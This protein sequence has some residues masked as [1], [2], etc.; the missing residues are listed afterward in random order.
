MKNQ[1]LHLAKNFIASTHRNLFLTGKAGT[2]K[3]T[4]LKDLKTQTYKRMVVVAPTGVA[5][6]NAGGVTI[7]S[8]FQMPFGPLV[9]GSQETAHHVK[10]FSRQKIDIIRT[11]DLLVID[12]ISMVR[13]DL[14]DGIDQTLRRFKERNR[15]FGGVQVL[16]IGDIQQLAP[17]VKQE[18]WGLLSSHY[19]TPFFFSSK[20]FRE[21]D[22]I[23]VEL[24]KIYRQENEDFIHIL[25]EIRN[26]KVSQN[27]LSKLNKRYNPNF[28]PNEEENYITLTTHNRVANKINEKKINAIDEKSFFFEAMI[29]GNF[30]EY[31]YPTH[32][33]LE[34]KKG[35]QVMFVKNDSSPEKRY[36]NGKIGTVIYVD[37][38]TVEVLCTG[39]RESI[40]VTPEIWENVNY[41]IDKETKEIKEEHIGSFSQIPL[42]WAWAIT[43]HKSQGLT[44]DKAIIDAS[45]SFAHGQTYV[46]LSRCRSLEGVVLKSKISQD[47]IINDY[48]VQSF[49]ESTRENLP[50]EQTLVTAQVS[51]QLQLMA[52][53][54]DFYP[55]VY[56]VQAALQV[57]HKNKNTLKGVLEEPLELLKNNLLPNLLK[58]STQFKK[59]LEQI[60]QAEVLPEKDSVIQER[61][62]KALEYYHNFLKERLI[63]TFGQIKF[64]T[65]NKEIRKELEK[66][67]ES[68]DDFLTQKLHVYQHLGSEFDTQKYLKIRAQAV[69]QKQTKPKRKRTLETSTEHPEL[70]TELRAYRMEMA[71]MEMIPVYQVFTQE[72]LYEIL[73]K[74][75]DFIKPTQENKRYG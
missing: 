57:Y 68:I 37:K 45:G 6:I 73:R 17:V 9:P 42:K 49:A 48:R 52:Q 43:I 58:I 21:A 2:G 4:F 20:A 70:F 66:H 33:K 13:A 46:A 14:L 34:L 15:P 38:E 30:P 44:F 16:M 32:E 55:L 19:E 39:E 67:L 75:T 5:A 11:L 50:D 71:E 22:V 61:F 40:T 56:A 10:K 63:E 36:Y 53:V 41:S 59:Q 27:T 8:F 65:D 29:R 64:D 25:E 18:E 7:H 31:S 69:L 24:Q 74:I 62:S 26:N 28:D 23:T 12:E 54:F 47:A 60:H 35:A 72:S 1:E 51:Y 3:T